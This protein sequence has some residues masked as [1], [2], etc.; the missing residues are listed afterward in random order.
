MTPAT[1]VSGRPAADGALPEPRA[2]TRRPA[3]ALLA[4]AGMLV[5]CAAA[6]RAQEQPPA[7][8]L[9]VAGDELSLDWDG[10]ALIADPAPAAEKVVL[11]KRTVN[12]KNNYWKYDFTDA[13]L[14]SRGSPSLEDGKT[15]V[16]RY[17]WGSLRLRYRLEGDRLRLRLRA[18]NRSD[19]PVAKFRFRLLELRL[20][21]TPE[22]LAKKRESKRHR[23]EG[24]IRKALDRPIALGLDA[25]PGRVF[26]TYDSFE[27][28]LRFGIG[29]PG[30]D[31]GDRYPLIVASGIKVFPRDGLVVPPKGLPRIPAGET[32][33]LDFSLRFAPAKLPRGQSLRGFY[34]AYHEFL[35]P[36]LDWPDR[37]PIGATYFY[38]EAGKV[39]AKY[40]VE[41][42]NPSRMGA[43]EVD[44]FSPHGATLLRLR[45]RGQARATVKQLEKM[46]AQGAILWNMTGN[47][48]HYVGAPRMQ[49][50]LAPELD[51][52]VDDFFRIIREAGFRVGVTIRQTQMQPRGG[53]WAQ[54]VGN[55]NPN[56][57]PLKKNFDRFI[58]DHHPWWTVYPIIRRLSDKIA[59]AK[60]RWGCTLFYWDT[61]N[62]RRMYGQGGS[63]MASSEP[64]AYIYR[65]LNE[66]HPDVLIIPELL[67]YPRASLAY[68]APYGQTGYGPG[69][70]K[71]SGPDLTRDIVPGYFGYLNI[72]D[73]GT[74]N[75][76]PRTQRL[77]SLV[78]GE[79]FATDAGWDS[80]AR[81]IAELRDE[82]GAKLTRINK[83]GRRF[84]LM[85][86]AKIT[87]P[88]PTI[89][90]EAERIP[91][92]KIVADWPPSGQLRV[93][94]AT[95]E[96]GQ[97]GMAVLGWYGYPFSPHAVLDD[98]LP[99]M[100][101]AGSAH[102]AWE[103]ASGDLLN[104]DAGLHVPAAPATGLRG[105]YVRAGKGGPEPART[106]GVRLGLAFDEGLAP[107]VGGGLLDDNGRAERT[108][109]RAGRALAVGA[110][111]G[112]AVYG[113]VP[114]WMS[115]TLEMDLRVDEPRGEPVELVRFRH[116]MKTTL[117]LTRSGGD[118]A[119]ELTSVE[120]AVDLNHYK[121]TQLTSDAEAEPEPRT[122]K[123]A[124]PDD[125]DW[126][127]VVL[128]WEM[129]QYLLYVD[130]ERKA[131]LSA[132]AAVR[133][134]DGTLGEPG[135]IFGAEAAGSGTMGAAVDSVF[136]YDWCFRDKDAEK[137]TGE[138]GFTPYAKP[139]GQKPTVWLWG[140]GPKKA[141]R[142]A[143]NTRRCENGLR[144]MKMRGRLAEKTDTGTREISTGSTQ[145]HKGIRLIYLEVEEEAEK[146]DEQDLEADSSTS[147]AGIEELE[148]ASN[149]YVLDVK[150]R[151]AGDDPPDRRIV[152]EFGLDK[153][154]WRRW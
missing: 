51:R 129:G 136:L 146:L 76:V 5:A 131:V 36:M 57:D 50:I 54:G 4:A 145:A 149:K 37:R 75:W 91:A 123:I 8:Q 117:T 135:L 83:L 59:Y 62:L 101:L 67:G 26:A 30:D 71:V 15:L 49:H 118:P 98:A 7:P 94:A 61:S 18:H 138:A 152:F 141:T 65:R 150:T 111:R 60:Q 133:H 85:Q 81:M 24:D 32:L 128:A 96:D 147:M 121:S 34:D 68:V 64:R 108:A 42:T 44:V 151:A 78:W 140:H 93:H 130:G 13:P 86:D 46:N 124:L 2:A 1:R 95:S 41:G 10:A 35:S 82:S 70:R 19:K 90:E 107:T 25:G 142:M 113:S 92:E 73:S 104:T 97:E 58:P 31:A 88:A 28:P 139:S 72:H 16:R 53:S 9:R 125:G 39:G 100:D 154:Q 20:P 109:G 116:H 112:K 148:K 102:R 63:K 115:G 23:G 126:H 143:V 48:G 21:E 114:N 12:P 47:Q 38:S 77:H 105:I 33:E 29:E 144:T 122:T 40:G 66:L 14:T 103:I 11:E 27:P 3:P 45:I 79:L 69:V 80:K 153:K 137:R 106:P 74:D 110:G 120:R 99:G 56:A 55:V 89:L 84:G 87:S 132:P 6:A 119:L 43:P 134:R 52:P 127:R 22:G 17:E